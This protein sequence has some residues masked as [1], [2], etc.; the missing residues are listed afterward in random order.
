MAT[1][2]K[3]GPTNPNEKSKDS[4]RRKLLKEMK[5]PYKP[6]KDL[7]RGP[8]EKE[9]LEPADQPVMTT[10]A[11]DKKPEEEGPDEDLEISQ[12]IPMAMNKR[13]KKDYN[14]A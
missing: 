2:R 4:R 11:E 3:A 6:N 1:P 14:K 13:K 5:L 7:P 9:L 8:S 10:Q 12:G